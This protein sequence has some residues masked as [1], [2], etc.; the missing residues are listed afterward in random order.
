MERERF[1]FVSGT[2]P[3]RWELLGVGEYEK[4]NLQ[5]LVLEQHQQ[6]RLQRQRRIKRLRRKAFFLLEPKTIVGFFFGIDRKN[7][8]ICIR[9]LSNVDVYGNI[10]LHAVNRSSTEREWEVRR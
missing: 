4:K 5:E 3:H 6:D 9:L 8:F 7:A 2:K 10:G 1:I